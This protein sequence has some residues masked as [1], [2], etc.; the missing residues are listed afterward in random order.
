VNIKMNKINATWVFFLYYFIS[1]MVC[2]TTGETMA[3]NHQRVWL[4]LNKGED[5]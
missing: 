3:E 4:E 1:P 5:K 2:I